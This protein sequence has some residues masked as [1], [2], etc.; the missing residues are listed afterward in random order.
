MHHD[1]FFEGEFYWF[2][3]IFNERESLGLKTLVSLN[4]MNEKNE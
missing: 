3:N 4:Y 1:A 2:L